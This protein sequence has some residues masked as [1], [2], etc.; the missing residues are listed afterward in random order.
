MNEH[1]LELVKLKMLKKLF[2][3]V[4]IILNGMK[5]PTELKEPD[6]YDKVSMPVFL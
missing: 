6:I 3:I 1:V 4:K 5:I 2:E